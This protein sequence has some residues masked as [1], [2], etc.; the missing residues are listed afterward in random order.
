M[1]KA[2]CL[3]TQSM[4]QRPQP[5]CHQQRFLALSLLRTMPAGVDKLAS[6]AIL[7]GD[8]DSFLED[9]QEC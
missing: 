2:D 7:T 3:R 8:P 4:V 5:V 9:H 6:D 1:L